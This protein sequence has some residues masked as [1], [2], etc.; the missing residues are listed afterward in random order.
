M[1]VLCKEK[2][3]MIMYDGIWYMRCMHSKQVLKSA[4]H[5]CYIYKKK[6]IVYIEEYVLSFKF[7]IH[8]NN[9]AFGSLFFC[10]P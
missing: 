4:L 10:L 5:A 9:T 7:P 8:Q 3:E 1:I 2:K 6:Y